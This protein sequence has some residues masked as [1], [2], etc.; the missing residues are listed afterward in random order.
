MCVLMY[1][2]YFIPI[3]FWE[4]HPLGGS[5]GCEMPEAGKKKATGAPA[6]ARERERALRRGG[7]QCVCVCV[8][9]C[10][11]VCVCVCVC[12]AVCVW[13]CVCACVFVRASMRARAFATRGARLRARLPRCARRVPPGG[14][15]AGGV[16]AAGGRHAGGAP[17]SGGHARWALGGDGEG[18]RHRGGRSRV[19]AVA[20]R[21]LRHGHAGGRGEQQWRPA[22]ALDGRGGPDWR[23]ADRAPARALRRGQRR[24][25]GRA[26]AEQ[27]QGR[28]PLRVLRR[29]GLRLARAGHTR[30]RHRLGGAPRQPPVGRRRAQPAARSQDQHRGH[31]ARAGARA[32]AL[33]AR[34]RALNHCR[35]RRVHPQGLHAGGHHHA[36]HHHVWRD[37]AR[38]ARG[39][40]EAEQARRSDAPDDEAL[41]LEAG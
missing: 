9:V 34:V 37:G 25:V 12:V 11:R 19:A 21:L 1:I 4:G 16:D 24:R 27:G 13:L 40:R 15:N 31:P 26:H 18:A 41:A 32:A 7:A 6:R 38:A 10:R 8:C 5:R 17:A 20:G 28:G 33:A 30:E 22:R 29:A 2:N 23:R 39:A 35:V 14:S 36:A 3:C